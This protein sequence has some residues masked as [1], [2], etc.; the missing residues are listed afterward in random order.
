M[1]IPIWRWPWA[2]LQD[3]LKEKHKD[4]DDVV[5]IGVCPYSLDVEILS[6]GDGSGKLGGL[7]KPIRGRNSV[8]RDVPSARSPIIGLLPVAYGLQCD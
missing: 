8:V 3:G 2:G 7:Y 1:S 5:L 6:E 4:L